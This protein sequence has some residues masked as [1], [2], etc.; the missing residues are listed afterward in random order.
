MLRVLPSHAKFCGSTTEITYLFEL[1]FVEKK[2]VHL[3]QITSIPI[4]MKQITS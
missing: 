4:E 2:L 1:D 3:A